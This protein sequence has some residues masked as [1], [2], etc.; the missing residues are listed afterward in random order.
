MILTDGTK[1]KKMNPVFYIHT[2]HLGQLTTYYCTLTVF[3]LILFVFNFI[4]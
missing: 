3:L 2:L 4:F 1:G